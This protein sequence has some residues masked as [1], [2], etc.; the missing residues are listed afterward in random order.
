MSVATIR[1]CTLLVAATAFAALASAA[2]AQKYDF[3]L[4]GSAD[5]AVAPATVTAFG[6]ALVVTTDEDWRERWKA[7]QGAMPAFKEAGTIPRGKKVSVLVFFKN[8]RPDAKGEVNV[9]CDLRF[10]RP[11]GTAAVEQKGLSCFRGRIEGSP[12]NLRLAGQQIDF[13]G[14]AKDPQGTWRVEVKLRDQVRASEV[15]LLSV[16]TLRG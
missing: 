5:R 1:P 8:A 11:D 14:D 15:T 10:L 2:E 9:A 16:F 3:S 4:K 12:A 7:A 6:G 13:V